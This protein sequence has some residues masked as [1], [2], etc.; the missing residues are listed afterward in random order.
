MS[1]LSICLVAFAVLA[2][3]PAAHAT[4]AGGNGRIVYAAAGTD[5][6]QSE[7]SSYRSLQTINPNGKQDRF[8]AGCQVTGGQPS[9]GN[10]EI[11]Y[12][13]PSWAP[14]GRNMVFDAGVSLALIAPNGSGLELFDPVSANDGQPVFSP[15]G[16]RIALTGRSGSRTDIHVVDRS[17]NGARRLVRDGASPDWSKR[18]TIAFVRR[19]SIHS[20]RSSGRGLRRLT[21]GRDPSWSPSGTQIAFARSGGIYVA[22]A[23]GSRARR[24]VRCSGCRTPAFSPDG[25]LLV[26]DGGGLRVVRVSDGKRV[27]TLVEDVRGAFDGSEPGWQAR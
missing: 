18:D 27:A 11:E 23:D 24:V 19:G 7:E 14:S 3:A 1:R 6:G 21:P 17:G 9:A 26:Y 2:S 8:V 5:V 15:S 20:V 4:F 13:S 25:R 12:G 16:R 10:C 22:N